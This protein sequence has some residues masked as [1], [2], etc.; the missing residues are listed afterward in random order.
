MSKTIR[1]RLAVPQDVDDLISLEERVWGGLQTDVYGAEQFNAWLEVHPEGFYVAESG[2]E[3]LGYIYGQ[4][5]NFSLYDVDNFTSCA[6]VTDHGTSRRTHQPDGD[7]LY[8]M[9]V[10][11][12]HPLAG[13]LLMRAQ[14]RMVHSK[15]LKSYFGFSRI[16][17][18]ADYLANL[19]TAGFVDEILTGEEEFAVAIWYVYESAGL[20]NLNF[21]NVFPSRPD[22]SLPKPKR[23]DPVLGWHLSSWRVPGKTLGVLRLLRKFMP[24]PQ[25]RDLSVLICTDLPGLCLS[26]TD[27]GLVRGIGGGTILEDRQ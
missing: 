20:G 19:K 18:F 11:S 9:S 6:V 7:S 15:K 16:P 5:M 25:S 24:D 26:Q 23:L 17:G 13:A 21:W 3:L 27:F 4:R 14:H 10:T 2:G 12:I 1:V 22:L 8:G